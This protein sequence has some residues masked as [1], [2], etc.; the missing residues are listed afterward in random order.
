MQT[1]YVSMLGK[2]NFF[3]LDPQKNNWTLASNLM[4]NVIPNK[5]SKVLWSKNR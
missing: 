3:Y 1:K 2:L 5:F 4:E